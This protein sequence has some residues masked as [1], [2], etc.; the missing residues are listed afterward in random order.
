[1]CAESADDAC[2]WRVAFEEAANIV[3]P[4][5]YSANYQAP[6]GTSYYYPPQHGGNQN[7]FI[8]DYYGPGRHYYLPP[9]SQII[10]V[11]RRPFYRHPGNGLLYGLALGSMMFW[12][13]MMFPFFC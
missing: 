4:A 12:P 13:W 2:A 11:D 5:P 3:L 9:N 7:Y 10:Y 1:M 6:Q 8:P